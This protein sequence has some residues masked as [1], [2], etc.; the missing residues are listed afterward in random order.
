[1]ALKVLSLELFNFCQFESLKY[2]LRDG[3]TRLTAENG[4][5]KTNACRGLV[6]ALTSWFDPS[7]G[8]QGDLL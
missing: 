7:W 2:D 6:Y 5:G 4:R 8:D 3:M 1:M